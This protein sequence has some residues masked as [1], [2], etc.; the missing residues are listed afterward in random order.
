MNRTEA[1]R[2]LKSAGTAQNRKVYARHGVQPPLFGVSYAALGKLRKQIGVDHK[3]ALALW[4]SGNHDARVLSTM[5]ADGQQLS[6]SEL[7][8]MV[9]GLNNYV[10]TDALSG[11]AAAAPSARARMNKWIKSRDEWIAT[12]GWNLVARFAARSSSA[13]DAELRPL[14][15]QIEARIHGAKNRV[16]YAMNGALISIG[17]RSASLRKDAVAAA[18]RI[19]VVE[20]DHGETGCKTPDAAAYIAKTLARRKQTASP[21]KKARAMSARTKKAR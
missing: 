7:D 8:A 2:A 15:A 12:A 19:G 21:K 3:L 14:I 17:V 10:L 13:Q 16:R 11:L 20:V 18:K 9:R 4:K 6:A 1:L 5:I